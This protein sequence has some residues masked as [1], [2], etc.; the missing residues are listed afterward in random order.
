MASNQLEFDIFLSYNWDHKAHVEK[1]YQKLQQL[2]L[3]VWIDD[4]ELDNSDLDEQLANGIAKSRVFMCCVTKKYSQS[5][6][7]KK[8][9]SFA[10]TKQKP[11]IV[12]ML[13]HFSNIPEG[14][15]IKINNHR[16]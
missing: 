13:E 14:F 7:C 12:L 16:R 11:M 1:L 3:T 4:V 6:N 5:E 10:T 2:N 9:F 15:Q 8:E